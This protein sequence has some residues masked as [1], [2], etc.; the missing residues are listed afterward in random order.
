MLVAVDT[1]GTK[2]LVAVFKQDG[3]LV[4]SVKFPTPV[5][6]TEY[7]SEVIK[8]IAKT[9]DT[10]PIDAIVVA[11][12]GIIVDDIVAWCPHLG[13]K[14]YDLKAD[15]EH[16]YPTT[17]ILIENDANLGGLGETRLLKKPVRSVLY[18]TIS[19]GI[20]TAVIVNGKIEPSLRS[21]EGGHILVEYDGVTQAWEGFAAGSAI[22]KAYGKMAKDIHSKRTW[23]QIADR[24]SRGFL[25]LL[26]F[27]QPDV[28]II[29]G[30]MGTHFEKYH[31]Q[32]VGLI[33]EKMPW[34][35][36]RPRFITAVHAEQAVIYGCYFY[37]LDT[38]VDPAA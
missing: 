3:T 22:Y 1:G 12:P 27:L 19:T 32:L 36:P 25:G 10:E 4:A 14:N 11:I 28:V 13:W 38:L 35:I 17:P 8:A 31:A 30:S 5:D 9:V 20:G 37:A 18:V 34:F 24:I 15:L 33:D 16:H 26:P 23:H 29:G 2:T 21:S 7:L 6:T